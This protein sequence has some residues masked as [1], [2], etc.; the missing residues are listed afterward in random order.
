MISHKNRISFL[1]VCAVAMP[2]LLALFIIGPNLRT[3]AQS[4]EA[5]NSLI[6]SSNNPKTDGHVTTTK[7]NP[8]YI[9]DDGVVW[10]SGGNLAFSNG[11]YIQTLTTIHGIQTV[12]VDLVSGSIE[13]YHK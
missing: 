8:I 13:L 11:G 1:S 10:N 2:L 3:L 6:L 5:T 12:E 7:G 4:N 9:H